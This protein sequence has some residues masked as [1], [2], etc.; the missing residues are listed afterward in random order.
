MG[1]CWV[2]PPSKGTIPKVPPFPYEAT[3]TSN[4]A[5]LVSHHSEVPI[6]C[7]HYGA[8]LPTGH[9]EY[10][11]NPRVNPPNANPFHEMW[12]ITPPF[13]SVLFH[14]FLGGLPMWLSQLWRNQSH[15]NPIPPLWDLAHQSAYKARPLV[16][17]QVNNESKGPWLWRVYSS[18]KATQSWH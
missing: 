13:W 15:P 3:M 5:R 1:I 12:F 10:H 2:Y 14:T 11:E 7:L 18:W 6:W 9:T 8:K 16:L 17:N 4:T